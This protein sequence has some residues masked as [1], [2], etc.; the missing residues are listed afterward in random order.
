VSQA[1][2]DRRPLA[3]AIGLF[4]IALVIR[5]LGITWG[6]PND[7]HNDS[8][9]PDETVVYY[10]YAYHED[11][12]P[13]LPGNYNYAT[14]Y[15]LILRVAGDV[16][17]Q[18]GGIDPPVSISQ[19]QS[20]D[21][22]KQKLTK[23]SKHQR[24]T[25]LAGRVLN[26]LAGAGMAVVI[27]FLLLRCAGMTAA[28]FGGSLTAI[29]PALV[30]HSRFQTVDTLAAFLMWLAILYAVKLYQN[31]KGN[32]FDY[33]YAILA[34]IFAGLSTG[35]KYT[36]VVALASVIAAVAL[37][38]DRN[39]KLWMAALASCAACAIAFVVSTPGSILDHQQFMFGVNSELEHM[40][41]GHDL[42]FVNTPSG[43]LYQ[44]GNLF[45]G[46]GPLAFI[47]GAF[48]LLYGAVRLRGW[49]WVV[50]PT[51]LIYYVIVGRSE[52]KFVRYG[53][54]LIPAVC[55]GFGYAIAGAMARP[56]LRIV[57]AAVG[58]LSIAGLESLAL[59]GQA[60]SPYW[61]C[62]DPRFGGAVGTFRYTADM[63]KEDP[64]DTAARY[65]F[66]TTA[67][68]PNASVGI[69]RVPWF[70]T[71]SVF[72]DANFLYNLP[73]DLGER[74]TSGYFASTSHPKIQR[75]YQVPS[76]QYAVLTSLEIEPFDRITDES[77]VPEMWKQRYEDLRDI[78]KDVRSNYT[79]IATFGGDAPAVEDL[80]HAQ[81]K[82]Y[83]L[84]H[85]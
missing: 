68:D 47:I 2:S 46:I 19:A 4:V 20:L 78:L 83:V 57:G 85:K 76:P 25:N 42:A 77:Q 35:T 81:P 3:A 64:R 28:L 48:G 52:V 66:S 54:P 36:G 69:F 59:S 22:L 73:S 53:L 9:H 80:M 55:I 16:T 44:L 60:P 82:A 6:L 45:T 14:L 50:L 71:V 7:L 74:M 33:R 72:K 24:A 41:Q 61:A 34:G 70:W 8:L 79:V 62:F 39:S 63:M 11:H 31:D 13:F 43:F 58:I 51:V 67:A 5:L 75:V 21:D 12:S 56:K 18:Y 38:K 23:N 30:M 49:M 26:C 1:S 37:R 10:N 15:P 40:K 29:A 84:R 27:F 32:A 17:A 65:V